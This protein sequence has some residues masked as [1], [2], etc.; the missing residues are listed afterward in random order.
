MSQESR[1]T[2][3][4]MYCVDIGSFYDLLHFIWD[5]IDI[6]IVSIMDVDNAMWSSVSE[7][8]AEVRLEMSLYYLVGRECIWDIQSNLL[9]SV[10]ELYRY[11]SGVVDVNNN[12]L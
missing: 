5:G 2:F 3:G 9:V 7:V 6:I 8:C 4:H 10:A 1:Y 12:K 11:T